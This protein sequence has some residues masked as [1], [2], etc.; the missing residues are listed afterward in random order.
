MLKLSRNRSAKLKKPLIL[1]WLM[2][3]GK[4]LYFVMIE[5]AGR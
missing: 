3:P 5:G 4:R 2:F 1:G